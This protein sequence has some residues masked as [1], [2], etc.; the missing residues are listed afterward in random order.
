MSEDYGALRTSATGRG[1]LAATNGYWRSHGTGRLTALPDGTHP[2]TRHSGNTNQCGKVQ[3]R[4]I[5][6]A[7][8]RT[9]DQLSRHILQVRIKPDDSQF[10]WSKI[11]LDDAGH[12]G[13]DQRF[14]MSM[15]EEQN[16]IS[17]VLP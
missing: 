4:P 6:F 8:I 11:P 13:I 2:A 7:G 10:S 12:I 5:S 14:G 9:G 15:R 16:R 3:Y 1:S 17:D